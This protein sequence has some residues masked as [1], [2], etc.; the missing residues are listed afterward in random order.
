MQ[1]EDAMKTRCLVIAMVLTATAVTGAKEPLSIRVSPAFSFAPANL[2][3]RTSVEPDAENRSME[4]IADSA[5]FYRSSRITLEGDR[6][7]KTM[8]VEFRS[9]PPGDYEVT[10][11]LIGGDGHRRA[12]AHAQVN[13]LEPGV[14]R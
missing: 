13:V 3:I 6:A 12:T 11:M 7:P 5:A 2:V 14:A 1:M 4:V 8:M 9:L 10:A